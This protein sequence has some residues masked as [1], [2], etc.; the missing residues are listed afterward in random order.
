MENENQKV[1]ELTIARI[2]D[3]PRKR[4]WRACREPA[5]LQ[6]WWG[7]PKDATMPVC[8]IDFR[9]GGSF[10]FKVEIPDGGVVWVKAIYKEI[11]DEEKLVLEDY[12]SDENGSLLNTPDFEVSTI[13][14]VFED[15]GEKTKLTVTHKGIGSQM[16]TIDQYQEGWS[17]SLDR[18]ADSLTN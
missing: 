9:V 11:V 2:F 17:Q 5:E 7:Q 10:H 15:V 13:T 4:V 18:L 12:F 6:K 8:E 14:L 3:A 16:H 1:K